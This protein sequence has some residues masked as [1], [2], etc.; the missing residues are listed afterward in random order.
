MRP[1]PGAGGS[2][3]PSLPPHASGSLTFLSCCRN[4]SP[5]DGVEKI[6]LYTILRD[7]LSASPQS[8]SCKVH[9]DVSLFSLKEGSGALHPLGPPAWGRSH[10]QWACPPQRTSSGSGGC[11]I[12]GVIIGQSS[13]S[14]RV[15]QV[16]AALF[17]LKE[18][19]G[20]PGS[21]VPVG[22]SVSARLWAQ[23]CF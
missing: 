1:S 19:G 4:R 7:S 11:P 20:F 15:L 5:L 23:M 22:H 13:L 10:V 21:L 6:P 17:P 2:L 8:S 12:R 18:S 3:L 14:R 9:L 16:S